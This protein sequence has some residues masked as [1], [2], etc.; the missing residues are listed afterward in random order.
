MYLH[1]EWI[2]LAHLGHLQSIGKLLFGVFCLL[3]CAAGISIAL[4]HKS[5]VYW[6]TR[7]HAADW[8]NWELIGVVGWLLWMS[9]DFL[10]ATRGLLRSKSKLLW[11]IAWHSLIAIHLA[12]VWFIRAKSDFDVWRFA[13]LWRLHLGVAA[14]ALVYLWLVTLAAVML[15]PWPRDRLQIWS[16]RVPS[17]LVAIGVG[18]MWIGFALYI[19]SFSGSM[20]FG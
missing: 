16:P 19:A 15:C 9:T 7:L 18:L 3:H 4:N 17:G 11:V 6:Y 1:Q 13:D 20:D 2:T 8:I 14:G 5:I 10:R 12:H